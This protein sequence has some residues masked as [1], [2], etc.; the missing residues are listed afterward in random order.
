MNNRTIVKTFAS[1]VAPSPK[2]NVLWMD[3]STDGNGSVIKNWN[4]SAWVITEN[5]ILASPTFTGTTTMALAAYANNTLA[6][7]GGLTVGMLYQVTGTGVVMCT[8]AG[9]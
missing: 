3:L 5:D 1:D 9:A 4:G 8:Q 7:D 6:L 2:A